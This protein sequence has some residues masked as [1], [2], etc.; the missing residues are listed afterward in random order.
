M[1]SVGERRH[2]DGKLED[3]VERTLDVMGALVGI[4]T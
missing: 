4:D 3:G 1:T 2:G